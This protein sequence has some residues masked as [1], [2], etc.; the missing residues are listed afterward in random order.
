MD[1]WARCKKAQETKAQ[2]DKWITSNLKAFVQKKK[3]TDC[4]NNLHFDKE[5]VSHMHMKW[6]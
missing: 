5:Y 1:F 2:I 3:E 4:K 6:G